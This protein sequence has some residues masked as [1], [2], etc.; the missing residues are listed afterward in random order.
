MVRPLTGADGCRARTNRR[1]GLDE[2]LRLR[3]LL[4]C[5]SV[6]CTEGTLM[7]WAHVHTRH[8]S[9]YLIH[10]VTPFLCRIARLCLLLAPCTAFRNASL[11]R[12]LG[13]CFCAPLLR[14]L[15]PVRHSC[16]RGIRRGPRCVVD[17]HAGALE[18]ADDAVR[19]RRRAETSAPVLHVRTKLQ[20]HDDKLAGVSGG[21][22]RRGIA[23]TQCRNVRWTCERR[24]PLGQ[25]SCPMLGARTWCAVH[26]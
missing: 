14:L 20:P 5:H 17:Q 25:P 19:A 4:R 21:R 1:L 13:L 3:A 12:R 10:V 11:P 2:E 23:I 18:T 26:A 15:F 22:I 24:K 6:T 9:P 7:G 16:G 8:T